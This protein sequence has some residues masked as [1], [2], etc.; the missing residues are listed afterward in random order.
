MDV[1]PYIRRGA[2]HSQSPVDAVPRPVTRVIWHVRER[3][4]GQFLL[5][6][7]KLMRVSQ[8]KRLRLA[9]VIEMFQEM[10]NQT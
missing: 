5:T 3:T 10:K 7:E 2:Q 1:V 9:E 4:H 6:S 8:A